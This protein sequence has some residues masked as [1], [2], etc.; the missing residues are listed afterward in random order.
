MN[1][2]LYTDGACLNNPG[3]GGW[4]ALWVQEDEPIAETLTGSD[5]DTTNNRM[6]LMAV[7]H[8]LTEPPEVRGKIRIFT[9]SKYVMNA[10]EEKWLVNWKKRGWKTAAKK[11]VKNKDLWLKL[12][13]LVA[14]TTVEWNWVKGHSG[15]KFNEWVDSEARSMAERAQDIG[16]LE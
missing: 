5:P 14:K 16:N 3:P 4:A 12:D 2:D 10:F 11:P 1:I 9:D 6:E 13:A 7:I 15:N 8:G